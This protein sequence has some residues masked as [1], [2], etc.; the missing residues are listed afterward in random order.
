MTIVVP[1]DITVSQYEQ[2]IDQ[3]CKNDV[4][5]MVAW[6]MSSSHK[7]DV[8]ICDESD[9]LLKEDIINFYEVPHSSSVDLRGLA[10]A[11]HG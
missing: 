11:F 9:L 4:M 10:A 2:Y 3:Y 5:V 8:F 7:S 1:D 6:N